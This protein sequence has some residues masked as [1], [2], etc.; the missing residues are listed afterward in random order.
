MIWKNWR[1]YRKEKNQFR[2][3]YCQTCH[4]RRKCF[5]KSECCPCYWARLEK[6]YQQHQQENYAYYRNQ[7]ADGEL[8][9]P[10][11]PVD[12]YLF[13]GQF[14]PL[15][16]FLALMK[17]AYERDYHIYVVDCHCQ[18]HPKTRTDGEYTECQN[19]GQE[20]KA[21]NNMRIIENR[22][23]ARFWNLEISLKI[24]C[25]TCLK[26]FQKLSESVFL[27]RVIITTRERKKNSQLYPLS[28][29]FFKEI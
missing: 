4:Q 29:T 8:L 9:N 24:L 15:S 21:A 2:S 22:N 14:Y 16:E 19:C 1:Q 28:H 12:H 17:S 11:A 20:L 26:N 23:D 6:R 25:L 27:L 10:K 18:L 5:L 13:H 7:R 3:Y